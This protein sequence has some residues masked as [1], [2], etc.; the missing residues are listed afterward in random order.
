MIGMTDNALPRLHK[1]APNVLGFC[2]YNGRGI[3]PGTTFGK[4]LAEHILGRV[5]EKD[6]PLPI[7][8]PKLPAVRSVKEAYYELGA[9]V[10][11]FAGERF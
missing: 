10:A 5:A 4:I 7:T 3:S 6:L 2:G 1:F 8:D 9:Q 11:H